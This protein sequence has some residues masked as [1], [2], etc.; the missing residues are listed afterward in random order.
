ME[1]I[2][3]IATTNDNGTESYQPLNVPLNQK[4]EYQGVPVWFFSGFPSAK[5]GLN[6]GKEKGFIF[7]PAMT[8][9]LWQN[10]KN[11]DIL[12]NHYLFSYAPSCAAQIARWHNIPYTIRTQGDN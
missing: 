11:Y 4:I 7:S 9:W 8:K 12:D 5:K 6:L 3:Q 1:L 2:A 10:I